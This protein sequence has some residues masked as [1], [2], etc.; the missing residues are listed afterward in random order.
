M[1]YTPGPFVH[2]SWH[3]IVPPICSLTHPNQIHPYSNQFDL[4]SRPHLT[5]PPLPLT[6]P[7]TVDE[8]RPFKNGNSSKN[9]SPPLFDEPGPRR[10]NGIKK[11]GLDRFATSYTPQWLAQLLPP[12]NYFYLPPTLSCPPTDYASDIFP[13]KLLAEPLPI[14]QQCPSILSDLPSRASVRPFQSDIASSD[15]TYYSRHFSELLSLHLSALMKDCQRS[16]LS[17][18]VIQPFLIAGL[19]DTYRIY[20]P[21]IREDSPRLNIGDRMIIRGLYQQMQLASHSVI[22]AEVVG[23]EKA[24]SWVYVRSPHLIGL[25][26]EQAELKKDHVQ[27]SENESNGSIV[28][29]RCQISFLL[30]V[31]PVCD[32]QDAVRTLGILQG[33][34]FGIVQRWLFPEI[35]HAQSETSDRTRPEIGWIDS[36]L[37]DEQKNAISEITTR[38]HRVPYLI[39]GPPGTGKTKTVVEAALQILLNHP[40]SYILIC[41]PSNSAA[42]TLAR[43][44]C[45]PSHADSITNTRPIIEP[46]SVLRLNH[47]SRTFAEVPGEILPFCYVNPAS[48]NSNTF[49]IPAFAQL[50]QYRV[51]ICTCLDAGILVTANATNITMMKAE[52]EMME[53]FHRVSKSGRTRD[54]IPHWTHL[55]IDEAAQA[56]EPETAIPISVVIPYPLPNGFR[57]I[58]PTVVLCGD[59][60]QL[61]PIISSLEARDGEL[62]VSLLERLFQREVYASHSNARSHQISR[63]DHPLSGWLA[64]F[65]N[66]V[67][68]YRSIAPILMIPAAMFYDDTLIP[69]ARDVELLRWRGLPNPKIPILFHGC[70]GEENWIDESWYNSS[71]VNAVAGLVKSLLESNLRIRQNDIAVITPWRE[72]VWRV[73]AKLRSRGYHGVDVGN[74]ETYQGA[75]FRVT[76]ISCVRSRERFLNDDRKANMGLFNERKRFNVAITRAKELLIVVGNANL[77]RRDPYWNGFLQIMLRNN[78][79]TGAELDLEMTGAYISR[80]ESTMHHDEDHDP[81]QAVLRLAGAMARETLRDD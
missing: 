20:V 73:R 57:S 37:N 34:G 49:G 14:A 54:V 64:P 3:E 72:Q 26:G 24:K 4:H 77:L 43:R 6:P 48:N 33:V 12:T 60:Q 25:D 42:D 1:S 19:Q 10:G 70:E 55:L 7:D 11:Q 39:S 47:P 15:P 28:G 21:G 80:L 27:Y 74:V 61:G 66:L 38:E 56:S 81:E 63:N 13:P 67:Q 8:F 32:M 53:T 16:R 78:L 41:A 31:K 65:T 35:H 69:V 50:M 17:C 29:I 9:P 46:G 62:E 76:I 44:L 2:P 23:L 52:S 18:T 36:G 45:L 68:N 79:Y 71:E 22:E 75:E 59:T 51:I 30:N 58:D 5:S 40:D